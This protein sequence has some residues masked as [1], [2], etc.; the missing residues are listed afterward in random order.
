MD[1]TIQLEF[2]P[3]LIRPLTTVLSTSILTPYLRD[4]TSQPSL[5]LLTTAYVDEGLWESPRLIAS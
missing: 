4:H 5:S 1:P 3:A 2:S